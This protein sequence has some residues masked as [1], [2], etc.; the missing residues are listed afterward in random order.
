[1]IDNIGFRINKYAKVSFV[2]GLIDLLS[3]YVVG[4][5][6]NY[7]ELFQL[8]ID[9]WKYMFLFICSIML[10]VY[11][12]DVLFFYDRNR[13][14]KCLLIFNE[15]FQNWQKYIKKNIIIN[16]KDLKKDFYYDIYC[17]VRNNPKIMGIRDDEIL[18]RDINVHLIFTNIITLLCFFLI[19]KIKFKIC[20]YCIG[21]LFIIFALLNFVYRNYL[22]YYINEIYTEYKCI[23]K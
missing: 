5:I 19:E 7:M 16:K 15:P 6:F 17:K 14:Y 8:I 3:F 1:M 2:I 22:K 11:F 4:R 13:K 10:V 23:K 12:F 18:I 21:L 9:K 20:L